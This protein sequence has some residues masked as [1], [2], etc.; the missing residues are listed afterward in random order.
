MGQEKVSARITRRFAGPFSCANVPVRSHVWQTGPPPSM[1][2]SCRKT[3]IPR[4]IEFVVRNEHRVVQFL[5][6]IKRGKTCPLIPVASEKRIVMRKQRQE[7]GIK[8]DLSSSIIRLIDLHEN[9][10]SLGTDQRL[11]AAKKEILMPL[12]IEFDNV[13]GE[14]GEFFACPNGIESFQCNRHAFESL[15]AF[16]VAWNGGVSGLRSSCEVFS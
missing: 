16:V 10:R 5:A 15:V 11:R 8:V 2:H 6:F 1:L 7:Q 3:T 13:D 4:M 14:A 9:R 12:N